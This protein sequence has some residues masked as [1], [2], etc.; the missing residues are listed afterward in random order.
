MGNRQF[1]LVSVVVTTRNEEKNIEKCLESITTQTYPIDKIEIIVVDNNSEDKTKVIASW[2][3]DKVFDK[4][5][6]RSS[7]RN[8]GAEK[9]TG[10]YLLYL[11]AD[12]S[13]TEKVVADCV[14]ALEGDKD[15][16]GLYISEIVIGDNFW[17][18]VRRFERS[19]YDTTVID[20]V[21]FIKKDKF[22]EIGG[23]DESLIGT[24]DW[25]IDK[26]IRDITGN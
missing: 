15:I 11:D 9:S 22:L 13:I 1:P 24:E 8:F 3:T 16:I 17:S 7:Q 25:D 26:R 20:A 14:S 5:P 21:R 6:E 2:F 10:L 19:F 4:G 12:M 23:F 18:K